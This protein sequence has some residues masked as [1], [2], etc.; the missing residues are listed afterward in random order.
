PSPRR[1]IRR[2]RLQNWP[3]PRA[4]EEEPL[5]AAS[6]EVKYS[7]AEYRPADDPPGADLGRDQL[8]AA[9]GNRQKR[10]VR[11]A[12]GERVPGGAMAPRLLGIEDQAAGEPEQSHAAECQEG[13]HGRQKG[14]MGHGGESDGPEEG[15]EG[16]T[17]G[18]TARVA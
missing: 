18:P 15:G 4:S 9:L 6:T 1:Q 2:L 14:H 12:L 11:R 7:H 13:G 17:Q 16:E 10:Q 8:L 5:L 3:P